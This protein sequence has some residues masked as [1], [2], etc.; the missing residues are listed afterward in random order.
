MVREFEFYHGAAIARLINSRRNIS[1]ERYPAGSNNASYV[2]NNQIGLYLKHSTSRL[3]PWVFTFK[4]GHQKEI[5]EMQRELGTV[6]VVLICGS[7]GMVCLDY[8]EFKV[9]LD[10]NHGQAEWIK[11]A[12][13][14]R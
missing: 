11:A 10:D 2:I 4:E 1:I 3:S 7:D 14:T 12:R 8:A 9:A 13:R 6:F 5:Q